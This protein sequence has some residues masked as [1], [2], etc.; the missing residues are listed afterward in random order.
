MHCCRKD[1]GVSLPLPSAEPAVISRRQTFR[2]QESITMNRL[3]GLRAALVLCAFAFAGTAFSTRPV[4]SAE[5]A[6]LTVEK[7]DRVI[8]IGNTLAERMQ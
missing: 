8:L 1:R 2:M 4:W 6:R 3:V 7:G 5:V